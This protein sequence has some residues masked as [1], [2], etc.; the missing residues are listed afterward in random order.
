MYADERAETDLF[1]GVLADSRRRFTIR[2]LADHSPTDLREIA[3]AMADEKHEGKDTKKADLRQSIYVTLY[4]THIIK[5]HATDVV[6]YDDRSK[7]VKRGP[8]HQRALEIIEFV[9][10]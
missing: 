9:D 8:N 6:E 10:S 3:I 4:Q 1:F 5:L 2:Y 7:V